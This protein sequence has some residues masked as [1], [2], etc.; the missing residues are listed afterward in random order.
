MPSLCVVCG[1]TMPSS[2]AVCGST[3]KN[4]RKKPSFYW[5]PRDRKTRDLWRTSLNIPSDVIIEDHHRVCSQDFLYGNKTDGNPT[6]QGDIGVSFGSVDPHTAKPYVRSRTL[7]Q[8]DCSF[9]LPAA[10]TY[11]WKWPFP[12]YLPYITGVCQ[13]PEVIKIY[14]AKGLL[15]VRRISK[16]I[17]G[18]F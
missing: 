6:P 2:C 15:K 11:A 12:L 18:Y 9:P 4:M 17:C 16:R 10:A 5:F 7:S 3:S 14:M 1:R 13:T 8:Q